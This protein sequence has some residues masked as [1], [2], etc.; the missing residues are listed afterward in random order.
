MLLFHDAVPANRSI[1][2]VAKDYQHGEFEPPHYHDC[3][4]LIHSLSG[5]VQVNTRLGS[6][7]VPPGRGVWLPAR[8]EHSLQI[9]GKVAARALL[10]DPLARADLPASCEV[11][12]ISPLLRELI[13]CAMDIPADYPAGGRE[14]RIMELI[15]D[16]LR[17]LPILPL[18]LPEPR[19]DAL[20]TLCRHIQQSLAHPWEL[21]QAARYI[22]VSGRTLSRRFQRETGLRFG[23]WVRRARL[24]AALNALAAGH[25]V[26]E[27]ALDLG[28][29][30]P[31]AF[32]AMF[33][34]QLG[35]APSTYFA[36]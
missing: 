34:R 17:V 8:V 30:S 24:L 1:V 3:A 25:S 32:S 22:N 11:V 7:V 28:Y 27:V 15:L 16:E 33:R 10:V 23:D 18:N 4:Q 26:L 14:E 5:V 12:Q 35:V 20:L 21:E 29:D 2:P 19:S 13:I 9:T 36:K 31:S 6:W